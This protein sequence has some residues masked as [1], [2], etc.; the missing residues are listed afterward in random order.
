MEEVN[1]NGYICVLRFR[2]LPPFVVGSLGMRLSM[3]VCRA[4]YQV[5]AA[6]QKK[7]QQCL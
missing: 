1:Y 5:M 3:C 2:L 6:V 4:A 7:S